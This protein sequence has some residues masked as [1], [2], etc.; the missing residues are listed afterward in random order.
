MARRVDLNSGESR[1]RVGDRRI[2]R[3]NR[4]IVSEVQTDDA[5]GRSSLSPV[6]H[7]LTHSAGARF[8]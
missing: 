4:F 8:V 2:S 3:T 1:G 7:Y 6:V 5:K